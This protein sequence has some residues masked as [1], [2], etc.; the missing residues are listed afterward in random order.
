M[1]I[2]TKVRKI[3]AEK[4]P[5]IDIED[6]VPQASLIEDLGADSLTIVELIMSMEEIFEIEIDDDQAEKLSTV[7]DIYDFIASKS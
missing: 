7:Q 4:I 6:V 1:T 2:E 5:D 3:I